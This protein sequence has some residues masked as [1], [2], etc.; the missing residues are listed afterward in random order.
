MSIT[1]STNTIVKTQRVLYDDW[2]LSKPWRGT[3]HIFAA[4]RS[5]LYFSAYLYRPLFL[6]GTNRFT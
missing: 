2:V 4:Y 1:H 6:W 3:T 5:L